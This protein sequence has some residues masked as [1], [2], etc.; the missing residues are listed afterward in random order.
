[1]NH[2]SSYSSKLLRI[3]NLCQ[4]VFFQNL[5]LK[6]WLDVLARSSQNIDQTLL[7]FLYLQLHTKTKTMPTNT[8][9]G[10]VNTEQTSKLCLIFVVRTKFCLQLIHAPQILSCLNLW[11]GAISDGTLMLAEDWEEDE[12]LYQSDMCIY[13]QILHTNHNY[14]YIQPSHVG[15]HVTGCFK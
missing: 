9:N 3:N 8:R 15:L 11:R 14:F 7:I 13:I 2:T 5:S 10:V 6:C 1:M 12:N 4:Q